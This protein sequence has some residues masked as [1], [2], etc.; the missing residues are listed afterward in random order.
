MAAPL[1]FGPSRPVAAYQGGS[2]RRYDSTRSFKLLR[3][4]FRGFSVERLML[5]LI[6]FGRDVEVVLRPAHARANRAGLVS[7]VW[8]HE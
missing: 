1:I 8:Q 7:K 3:G 4:R 5:M 6:A 2:A